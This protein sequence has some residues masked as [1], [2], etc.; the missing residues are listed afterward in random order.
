MERLLRRYLADHPD[1]LRDFAQAE[2]RI[3]FALNG[4]IRGTICA[5]VD[6]VTENVVRDVVLTA[7]Y[8]KAARE[9]AERAVSGI[10]QRSF[11]PRPE[12]EVCMGYDVSRICGWGRVGN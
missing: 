12:R 11:P 7:R 8:M 9:E 2:T 5:R 3:E 6:L 1:V 4:T 10:A